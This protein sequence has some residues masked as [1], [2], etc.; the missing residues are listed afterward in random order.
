MLTPVV[1]AGSHFIL[2][3]IPHYDNIA[4]NF[5]LGFFAVTFLLYTAWLCKDGFIV[6]SALLGLLPDANCH[7]GWSQSLAEFHRQCHFTARGEVP[8][9]FLYLE[10]YSC[11][12]YCYLVITRYL[13]RASRSGQTAEKILS[14]LTAGLG[15]FPARLHSKPEINREHYVVKET[16]GKKARK[17]DGLESLQEGRNGKGVNRYLN[18]LPVRKAP[19]LKPG[20]QEAQ[21]T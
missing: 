18:P 8:I 12:I 2:D 3:A 5:P 15:S 17:D 9:C 16:K 19:L 4:W 6:L 21:Q 11:L 10:I 14:Y 1:A 7:F 13:P 20:E